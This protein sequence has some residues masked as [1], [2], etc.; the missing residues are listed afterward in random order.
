MSLWKEITA[1]AGIFGELWY[2]V[3]YRKR[4]WLIP[5]LVFLFLLSMFIVFAE[6]SAVAPF[7]YSIF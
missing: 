1:R 3:R 2:F 5:I 6:S 7:I 4:Y